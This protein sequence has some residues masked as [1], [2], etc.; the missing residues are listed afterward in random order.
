MSSG[1]HGERPQRPCPGRCGIRGARNRGGDG[2]RAQPW[3]AA[4]T[5]AVAAE[6]ATVAGG[7]R[8]GGPVRRLRG[9]LLRRSQRTEAA[10]PDGCGDCN[11]R[12]GCCRRSRS[13]RGGRSGPRR[14]RR[15]RRQRKREQRTAATAAGVGGRRPRQA[16]AAGGRRP[17]RLQPG[18]PA[19]GAATVAGE[20]DGRDRGKRRR[21]RRRPRRGR[22]ER[23]AAAASVDAAAGGACRAWWDTGSRHPAG[24]VARWRDRIF[25]TENPHRQC[26]ES[27]S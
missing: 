4:P 1:G 5:A 24:G 21:Q 10:W 22:R 27:R 11:G 15:R 19:T 20:V 17:R 23:W 13:D 12:G 18:A 26:C 9:R 2:G 7:R 3:K 25:V 16:A 6:A 8:V 14:S